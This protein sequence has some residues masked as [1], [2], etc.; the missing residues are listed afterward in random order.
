M[1]A[2]Q[3]WRETT[4]IFW[5]WPVL[6]LPV[7]VADLA[8]FVLNDA[9]KRL[10]HWLA[11]RMWSTS[12]LTGMREPPSNLSA[13]L[14]TLKVVSITAPILWGSYFLHV[15]VYTIALFA[16][17]GMVRRIT[18]GDA[19]LPLRAG[20]AFAHSRRRVVLRLSF[21][22]FGLVIALAMVFFGALAFLEPVRTALRGPSIVYIITAVLMCVAA[23]IAV[24]FALRWIGSLIPRTASAEELQQGRIF[25][26]ATVAASISLAY[27]LTLVQRTTIAGLGAIGIWALGAIG[28]LVAAFPYVVLFIALTRIVDCNGEEA[29][30]FSDSGG[31]DGEPTIRH[32]SE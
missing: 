4:E 26:T 28:S 29:P 23:C 10:T 5:Q 27:G 17:V 11:L 31:S 6:W 32:E 8:V 18:K 22:I 3:V 24:G 30:L 1:R 7:L 20:I 12:G 14:L 16:T 9:T 25:S 19:T 13:H 15:A 21:V 2:R